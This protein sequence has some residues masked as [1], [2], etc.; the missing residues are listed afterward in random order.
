VG[1]LAARA[2]GA[3]DCTPAAIRGAL[4]QDHPPGLVHVA[5][6]PA[7]V[8]DEFWRAY[9]AID[10]DRRIA[11]PGQPYQETDVVVDELPMR[12]LIVAAASPRAAFLA[13]EKGGRARTRHLF[14]VC[15]AGG[16]VTG[17]YSA[18]RAPNTFE[19]A[20]LSEALRDGCLVSPP[21]EHALPG[22]AARCPPP[23]APAAP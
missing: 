4:E 17:A 7:P 1:L 6:L 20:A 21:R 10:P 22:D 2:A 19:R 18:L 11:D 23:A 12:R 8:L 5:E 13:Y 3:A 9:G 15:L 16:Q 14:A